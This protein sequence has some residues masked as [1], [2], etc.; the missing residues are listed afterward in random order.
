M[1][2]YD[3]F[4]NFNDLVSCSGLLKVHNVDKVPVLARIAGQALCGRIISCL[5]N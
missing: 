3:E 5:D 4:L 1:A 2:Y